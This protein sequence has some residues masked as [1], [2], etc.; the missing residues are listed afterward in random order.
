MQFIGKN[1]CIDKRGPFTNVLL[2]ALDLPQYIAGPFRPKIKNLA[3]PPNAKILIYHDGTQKI[4]S[5]L[6]VMDQYAEKLKNSLN[7]AASG[8][9]HTSA[10]VLLTAPLPFQYGTISL[11]L[12]T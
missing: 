6:R 10:F 12:E 8:N 3:C 2:F 7:N 11:C 4:K 9:A 5:T 1:N